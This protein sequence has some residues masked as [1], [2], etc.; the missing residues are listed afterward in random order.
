MAWHSIQWEQLAG[1]FDK[2]DGSLN[3]GYPNHLNG[4]CKE[5]NHVWKFKKYQSISDVAIDA[6][7]EKAIT[8]E[9]IEDQIDYTF[10]VESDNSHIRDR[11]IMRNTIQ[12][13]RDKLT[14]P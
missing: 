9:D 13:Y 4:I 12:W 2:N 10:P 1:K 3:E 6:L 11:Q 8:D 7:P 5:C 14:T